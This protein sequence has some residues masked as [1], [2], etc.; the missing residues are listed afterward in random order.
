MSIQGRSLRNDVGSSKKKNNFKTTIQNERKKITN[1]YVNTANKIHTP[2]HSHTKKNSETIEKKNE[3][4]RP[5][6]P[7]VGRRGQPINGWQM[8]PNCCCSPA[9]APTPTP[10]RAKQQKSLGDETRKKNNKPTRQEPRSNRV[11]NKDKKRYNENEEKA[12][13]NPVKPSKSR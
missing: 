7:P 9:S 1:E 2:T 5:V 12:Q 4:P 13:Q 11:E 10:N 3:Q 8:A 6:A